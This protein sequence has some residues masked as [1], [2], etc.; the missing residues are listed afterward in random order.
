M[1]WLSWFRLTAFGLIPVAVFLPGRVVAVSFGFW[2]VASTIVASGLFVAAVIWYERERIRGR[3]ARNHSSSVR[4][5]LTRLT[6]EWPVS[7]PVRGEEIQD[8]AYAGDLQIVGRGSLLQLLDRCS[9]RAGST[10]LQKLL[11][12][13]PTAE[14]VREQL[15]ACAELAPLTVFRSRFARSGRGIEGEPDAI[16]PG[17]DGFLGAGPVS[18]LSFFVWAA[19]LLPVCTAAGY[20]GFVLGLTEALYLVT[21]PLQVASFLIFQ[22]VSRAHQKR[23]CAQ[24]DSLADLEALLAVSS[25]LHAKS[26][27]L[28]RMSV[29]AGSSSW[30]TV[31]SLSRATGLLNLRRNPL[32]HAFLGIFFLYDVHLLARIERMRAIARDSLERWFQ[33]IATLDALVSIADFSASRPHYC[34]PELLSEGVRLQARNLRHP[35][36]PEPRARG[37]DIDLD[38]YQPLVLVSGSNM[39]GKSTLLRSLG[40]GLVLA[41]VG[42]RVP[43][44]QFQFSL[45]ELHSSIQVKDDL[46]RS[47]SLFYAEVR[48]I[49]SILDA[50][51]TGP[52]LFLLDEILRGTNERERHI[53]VRSIIRNLGRSGSL[54]LVATHDVRLLE[55][56][57]GQAPLRCS[58]FQETVSDDGL[59]VFDYALRPGPVTGSNALRL[60]RSEGIVIDEEP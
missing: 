38:E 36:L 52:V 2:T 46:L 34:Q 4:D 26:P 57:C 22:V 25:T 11:T 44:D 53:A 49:K 48:R 6:P 31:R 14:A 47:T 29:F 28:A 21:L 24:A 7:V 56:L 18:F 12:A 54:G 41:R 17:R 45:L 3:R 30:V 43:A 58:H 37:N 19:F 23:A 8:H 9:T 13:E 50:V 40:L 1:A 39:S 16:N 15:A 55:Q 32:A 27:L 33:E 10:C 51:A 60:L 42:A 20:A 5:L 35:F 59:M